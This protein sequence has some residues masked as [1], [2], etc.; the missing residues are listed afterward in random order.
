MRVDHFISVLHTNSRSN[1]VFKKSY[2][3]VSGLV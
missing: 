3:V 1:L 2:D